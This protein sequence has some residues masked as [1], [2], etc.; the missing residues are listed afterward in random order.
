MKVSRK[1]L[2]MIPFAVIACVLIVVAILKLREPILQNDWSGAYSIHTTTPT[3]ALFQ[4]QG[5][6]TS[7]PT[8]PGLGIIP[9]TTPSPTAQP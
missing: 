8:A 9:T 7:M 3:F 1:F 5:W 4:E 2:V 6:W